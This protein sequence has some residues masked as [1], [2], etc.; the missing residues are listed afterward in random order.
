[1][2]INE[3]LIAGEISRIGVMEC[4]GTGVVQQLR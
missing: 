4:M 3:G 1:M 2:R